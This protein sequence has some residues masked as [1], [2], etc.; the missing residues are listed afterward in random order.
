MKRPLFFALFFCILYNE[1]YS[2]KIIVKPSSKNEGI[3][4]AV[5]HSFRNDTIIIKEGTYYETN[6]VITHPLTIIGEN[7]PVIDA[8]KKNEIF[9]VKSSFVSIIG[10]TIKNSGRSDINDYAGIKVYNASFCTI[11]NNTLINTYFGIYLT[12]S[13]NCTV[14]SNNIIGNA[15]TETASGNGI[16]FW[17]TKDCTIINNSIEK[18]RDGIYF[19]FVTNTKII[20]N[21][22]ANNLRYGLHFMFSDGNSYERN[23]FTEN[24]AG[25]AVMYTKNIIMTGNIFENNWG[26]SSYGLL[27]KE[28][29]HSV[30]KNNFFTK[31]TIGIFMEGSNSLY[32]S[33]NQFENNGWAM[34]ILANC[35]EDTIAQNNF[36]GN[37]FDVSTNGNSNENIY[38]KNYWDNY[39]GYDL[40]HDHIGDIPF[41]PVSL[42]SMVV[43]QIPFSIILLRSF[44]VDILNQAEKT[45][46][47]FIPESI[48]DKEPMLKMYDFRTTRSN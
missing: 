3:R 7:N 23:R 5:L 29:S 36:T 42:F 20:H 10:L 48:I 27:L 28:I 14:S 4:N 21:V 16:H 8:Q 17:K 46:P 2:K 6:I 9:S 18:H 43:E 25:V 19:E 34:K 37:S 30:I 45:V 24:G 40:N 38:N 31:N 41:R 13:S 33:N 15:V 44:M 47:V 35:S 32:I 22:S 1:G 11:S 39:K 26:P 12:N